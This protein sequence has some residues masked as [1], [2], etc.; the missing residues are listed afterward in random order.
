M[1]DK[2]GL[3]NVVV[4]YLSP[5]GPEATSREDLP[6]DNS[7]SDEQ[8]L[9]ISHQANPWYADLV[10]FKV[11]GVL[12]LGL[13]HQQRKKF[14]S[15]AKYFLWEEPLLYK[16][17]RHGVYRWCLLEDEVQSVLHHCHSSRYGG[18]FGAE[19]TVV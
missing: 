9:A 15:D 7:F 17:C 5:P 2:A 11:Y 13:S 3:A 12:P 16:L 8:L 1:K 18:H 19:K 10:N 14:F 4:D 6:I